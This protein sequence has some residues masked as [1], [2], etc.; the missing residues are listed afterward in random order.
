MNL[1]L[2][3]FFFK[4]DFADRFGNTVVL[5]S[6]EHVQ[7][8]GRLVSANYIPWEAGST[9]TGNQFLVPATALNGTFLLNG[10]KS[11]D[12]IIDC[13]YSRFK[14]TIYTFLQK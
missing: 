9:K 6:F 10:V 1:F 14:K 3:L 11:F 8:R 4:A 2:F 13:K 12:G 5:T 7:Y